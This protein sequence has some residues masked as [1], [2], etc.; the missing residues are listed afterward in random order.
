MNEGSDIRDRL[1]AGA[2]G[3]LIATVLA[4]GTSFISQVWLARRFGPGGLGEYNATSL[5]VT[6]LTTLLLLGIP[7]AISERVASLGEAKDRAEDEAVSGALTI[8]LVL[9]A[10]ATTAALI[11]WP[12][13]TA[14]ARLSAPAPLFLLAIATLGAVVQSF[15]ISVLLA[16]LQMK[17]ATGVVLM[18]PVSVIAGLAASY[19]IRTIDGSTLG[20]IGFLAG[21]AA[22]VLVLV[23]EGIRPGRPRKETRRIGRT[24]VAGTTFLYLTLLQSW[25]DRLVVVVIAGPAALGAFAVASFLGE[26]ILRVPRN[27]GAFGIA[28]YA[29]LANDPVGL[30]RV[31]N[32]QIRIA[33]AF[34]IV[35]AAFLISAGNGLLAVIFGE[36][37]EIATTTLRLLAIALV[38]TG[39]ALALAAAAIGTHRHARLVVAL[40]ILVPVQVVLAAIGAH[41]AGIGGVALSGVL[42][43]SL[44]VVILAGGPRE[45]V[46]R[47]GDGMLLRIVGV[48][49]PTVVAA[50]VIG[51]DLDANWIFRGALSVAIAL[52]A[53][54]T[55][56]VG[57]PERRILRRLG[58]Q[59][60][61]ITA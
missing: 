47:P 17:L 53:V 22:S 41:Y 30:R 59:V 43:W 60:A 29:R 21:G 56:L 33:S 19:A 51:S 61:E 49:A 2:R 10:I 20:A 3:S 42:L 18:Q 45:H 38:P 37:F 8:V 14:I 50:L 7:I 34:F 48:A 25:I 24:S 6:I 23:A 35:A 52:I 15:V 54:G 28:A 12:P 13:F 16:R 5:F 4:M 11:I 46:A 1:S 26:A 27:A 36:G 58:G 57:E 39:V 55:V 40:V 31:L 44:A 32:S 9:G